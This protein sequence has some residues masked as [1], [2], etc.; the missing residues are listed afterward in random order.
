[1]WHSAWICGIPYG[2]AALHIATWCHIATWHAT[3]ACG[4]QCVVV[5]LYGMPNDHMAIHV[6]TRWTIQIYGTT[7]SS[8]VCYAYMAHRIAVYGMR[9]GRMVSHIGIWDT[10]WS[11]GHHITIW[12]SISLYGAPYVAIRYTMELSMVCH[13]QQ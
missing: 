10:I 1:M 8:M 5:P 11:Y 3:E 2:Y 9:Y 4:V 7:Y 13:L 6:A 12:R